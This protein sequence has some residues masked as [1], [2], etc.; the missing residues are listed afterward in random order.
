MTENDYIAEYIKEKY[1][2]LLGFDFAVWKACKIL[3]KGVSEFVEA[4]HNMSLLDTEE[5]EE[6]K[7]DGS[8]II[9]G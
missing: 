2:N 5:K 9:G 1:S 8:E 3:S 6:E 4:V 7:E